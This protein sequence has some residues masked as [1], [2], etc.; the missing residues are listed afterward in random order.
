MK[1]KL[2][3][4]LIVIALLGV[5]IGIFISSKKFEV[6]LMDKRIASLNTEVYNTDFIVKVKNGEITSKKERIDTSKVGKQT[7]T[8]T[9]KN[10]FKKEE[11][12]T[13]EINIV[14][15]EAPT[16]GYKEELTTTVGTEIDLL[17]NVSATDNSGEEIKVK[18][19]GEYDFKKAG[20]Y[21]LYYVAT[22]SSGNTAKKSFTLIVNEKK[23]SSSNTSTLENAEYLE[24]DGEFTTRKGFHGEVKNGIVYVE[25]YLI[26]NKTYALPSTYNPGLDS[27]TN[28]AA[29]KMFSDAK[30]L[31]YNLYIASGF[32]SYETQKALYNR[33][34]N[35]DGKESADTYSA[36]PGHSEHQSCLAFDVCDSNL[37]NACINK[38]FADTD[39]AKWLSEN[40]YKYG[41]ILRYP[42][43]KTNETGYIYE[44]WHFR[45][46]GTELAEKLY[47]NGNWITMEDYFGLTSEY[48][49]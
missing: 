2:I 44:S 32:R 24:E 13:Y 3:I 11:T 22:D 26:A 14:D 35:R 7:I 49:Y 20:T 4:I 1:K 38:N 28:S 6:T 16:I 8:I 39:Q 21:K 47:D 41:F 19:E 36:R 9:C 23:T 30:A 17:K 31:G 37:G 18:V 45:Y 15:N 33:Y 43:D 48:S 29:N 42:K 25:G 12:I 5:G 27:K 10:F 40:A 34:V 46:V